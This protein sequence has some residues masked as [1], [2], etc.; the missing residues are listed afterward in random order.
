MVTQTV[1]LIGDDSMA[2]PLKEPMGGRVRGIGKQAV[3]INYGTY[4]IREITSVRCYCTCKLYC[5][6]S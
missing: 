3:A 6:Y 5:K 4:S 1:L 2:L